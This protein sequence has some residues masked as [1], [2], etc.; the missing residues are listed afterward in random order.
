VSP[1]PGETASYRAGA[2][3][4]ARGTSGLR[5]LSCSTVWGEAVGWSRWLY[6]RWRRVVVLVH[7]AYL[8]GSPVEYFFVKVTNLSPS[9]EV[10]ITH[11]WFD[12]GSGVDVL[13]PQRPLPARL[14]LDETYETWFPVAEV[15][16]PEAEWLVRV[17]LSSGKDI[18]ARLNR[19]VRP[20]GYVAG[21]GNQ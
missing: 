6:Q 10:E 13:N 12:A 7:R 19:H 16:A 1:I 15:Q 3:F 18:K 11:I 4:L 9:R 17:R 14:R 8:T 20:F 21:G 5:R 2:R